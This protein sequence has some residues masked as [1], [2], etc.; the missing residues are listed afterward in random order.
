MTQTHRGLDHI[1]KETIR[2]LDEQHRKFLYLQDYFTGFPSK[3]FPNGKFTENRVRRHASK[4]GMTFE[5]LINELYDWT[6][7]K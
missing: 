6:E 3:A 5:T 2:E 7:G 1:T 4:N